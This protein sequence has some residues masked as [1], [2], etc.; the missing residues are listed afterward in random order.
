[1]ALMQSKFRLAGFLASN[2]M[3]GGSA[4]PF[5]LSGVT[6]LRGREAHES[7]GVL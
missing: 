7:N 5:P 6:Y 4:K 2:L 3:R 1:M